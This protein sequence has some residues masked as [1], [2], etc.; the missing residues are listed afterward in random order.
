MTEQEKK[1]LLTLANVTHI[2][3]LT[4]GKVAHLH[5]NADNLTYELHQLHDSAEQIRIIRDQIWTE[6][7][8]NANAESLLHGR[9]TK[10]IDDNQ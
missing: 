4:L 1:L 5:I 2:T 9:F 8:V 10:S 7:E 6:E 3:L